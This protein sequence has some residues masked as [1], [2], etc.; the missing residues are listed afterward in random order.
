MMEKKN[1]SI[2]PTKS[3]RGWKILPIGEVIEANISVSVQA[4]GRCH[5][6]PRA[7]SEP[8]A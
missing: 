8:A 6:R 7:Y 2:P 3:R 1:A 4:R 5:V